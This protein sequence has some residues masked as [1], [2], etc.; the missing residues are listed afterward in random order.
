MNLK[1][2]LKTEIKNCSGKYENIYSSDVD[3]D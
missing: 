3:Y 1:T 2:N